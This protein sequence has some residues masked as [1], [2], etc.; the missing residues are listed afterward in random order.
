M[1]LAVVTV[2]AALATQPVSDNQIRGTV[3]DVTGAAVAGASVSAGGPGVT[4]DAHGAFTIASAEADPILVIN[5]PGFAEYA[6]RV[7]PGAGLRIVLQPAGIAETLT[8]TAAR[9][10]E[11][12]AASATATA[13][14][15]A[16]VLLTSAALTADDALRSVPGFSLFRRS[17]SRVANPTTQGA[18][19]RGLAASG[20]S[21]ALVLADGVP[22]NDPFGGWVYWNRVPQAAID[23]IEVVRGGSA[24]LYGNESIA[25]TIQILT[26]DPPAATFRASA[27]TGEGGMARGTAYA[28]LRKAGWAAFASAERFVLDGFPIVA[29]DTRGP[30]DTDAGLKYWSGL[31]SIGRQAEQWS[32]GLRAGALDEDRANGTPLQRNDTNLRSLSVRARGLRAAGAW[33]AAV[34]GGTVGYDQ[35]FSAVTQGRTAEILTARQRVASAHQSASVQWTSAWGRQ[36]LIVGGDVTRVTA[37]SQG[38]PDVSQGDY[39]AYAQVSARPAASLTISAGARAGAWS[40]GPTQADSRRR[41]YVMPRVSAAWA[42]GPHVSIHA[43]WT[44]P[45]RTPTLNELYR[46]FQVG[47]T[48]TFAN[49]GLTPEKASALEGGV[50]L[51]A[52][53]G[54]ARLVGFWTEL[55]DAITNVTLDVA[56][57]RITR[58]RQNAGHIRARGVEL[59]GEWRPAGWTAIVASAAL[60][61]S[62]FTTSVEPGL[63][64]RRVPQVPRWT[65]AA[66]LR[67]TPGRAVA[68]IDVRTTGA[69]FDDDRNQLALGRGAVAD[70]YAGVTLRRIQP[71]IA[72]EN[73][74]DA[75]IDV[76]RTPVRTV[77]TPR[78]ARLGLRAFL[79]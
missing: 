70:F 33:T 21:R 23:R 1:T 77:G 54:S 44:R 61:D 6:A 31:A 50:L 25:G 75:E 34:S 18:T 11:R 48:Y 52:R 37:T 47:S 53:R 64:G 8:V 35:S 72:V 22:L 42:A 55:G 56:G 29:A 68:A 67:L 78:T 69:Q 62:R 45:G 15:P 63:A 76:G 20:A 13:V 57:G 58:E 27:E 9:S 43:S 12:L 32:I 73:V 24:E 30:I 65:A 46:D 26:I 40:T 14:L 17:S 60:L 59:E 36:S 66:S 39:A 79:P 41:A 19:L 3:V 71:F 28:G 74:F 51:H 2:L 5:A 16:S 38:D 10:Q 7:R 49:G 4:T